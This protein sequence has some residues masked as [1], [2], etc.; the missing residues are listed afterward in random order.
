MKVQQFSH[1]EQ[2]IIK[3]NLTLTDQREL[4]PGEMKNEVH[5]ASIEKAR[6][7]ILKEQTKQHSQ[8]IFSMNSSLF[9]ATDAKRQ[10]LR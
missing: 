2:F 4:L 1:Y 3:T 6:D 10:M 8:A 5:T 7:Q 9:R